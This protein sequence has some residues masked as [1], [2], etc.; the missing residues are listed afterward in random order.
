MTSGLFFKLFP[1]P[2]YLSQPFVGLDISDQSIKFAE[3]GGVNDDKKLIRYGSMP[4]PTGLIESGRILDHDKF[5]SILKKFREENHL[6]NVVVSL[7]EEQAFVVNLEIPNIKKSELRGSIELQLEEYVPLK[8]SEIVFDYEILSL[9]DK[10]NDNYHISVYI[11]PLSM[12]LNYFE[13]LQEAEYRPLG[14]E[15]EGQSLARAVISRQQEGVILIVD[16]G[17]TRTSFIIVV[18]GVVAFTSTVSNIGGEDITKSIAKNLSLERAEA[19]KL[20]IEKGLLRSTKDKELFYSL[21]PVVSA[22]AD[23]IRRVSNYWKT[24]TDT[25]QKSQFDKIILTGGQATLFGLDNY[26]TITLGLPT[27]ISNPW[28]NIFSLEH[29]IPTLDFNNAQRYVTALGLALRNFV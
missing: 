6:K 19:E 17:K 8:I 15:I 5:K 21:I 27:E 10:A 7:P 1:P 13:V 12:V 26:L 16:I 4:I 9:P 25:H 18:N 24:H 14:F 29:K 22:L 11:L 28:V 20:K 23:E 2:Q 3:L